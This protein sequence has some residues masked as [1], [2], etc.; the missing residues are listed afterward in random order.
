MSEIT[1]YTTP[2]CV[3]CAATK[4]L[5]DSLGIDYSIVDLSLDLDAMAYV[6][7]LGYRMAPI[8]IVGDTEDHWSGF[9]PDRIRAHAPVLQIA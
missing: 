2:S 4:R 5:M 8:V 3:Q 1:V 7:S 9:Q 6:K